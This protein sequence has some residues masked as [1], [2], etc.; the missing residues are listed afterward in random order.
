MLTL[1]LRRIVEVINKEGAIMAKI[2]AVSIAIS[3]DGNTIAIV[4]TKGRVWKQRGQ[5]LAQSIH[6]PEEPSSGTPQAITI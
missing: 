4:D 5:S 1:L 3:G 6:M 2:K